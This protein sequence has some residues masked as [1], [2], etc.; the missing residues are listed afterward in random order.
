MSDEA[1]KREF[2]EK[3]IPAFV[4][5]LLMAKEAIALYHKRTD[6]DGPVA[7]AE[8]D[9]KDLLITASA[10]VNVGFV[11]RGPAPDVKIE[12][13]VV[14]IGEMT[15]KLDPTKVHDAFTRHLEA[16]GID[17]KV[18]SRI[19]AELVSAEPGQK[20]LQLMLLDSV[21]LQRKRALRTGTP[22][23]GDE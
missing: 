10:M 18:A 1:S 11:A 21:M 7:Y 22:E 5:L 4:D 2:R 14:Q 17:L 3:A 23:H 13:R 9:F 12:E 20:M 19:L 16:D 6:G 15:V 8:H